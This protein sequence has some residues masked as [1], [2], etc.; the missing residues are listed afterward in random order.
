MTTYLKVNNLEIQYIDNQNR[1]DIFNLK[2]IFNKNNTMVCR[3]YKSNYKNLLNIFNSIISGNKGYLEFGLNDQVNNY[4]ILNFDKDFLNFK[5]KHNEDSLNCS[6][7]EI[8]NIYFE[9]NSITRNT[10][11]KFINEFKIPNSVELDFFKNNIYYNGIYF[12]KDMGVIPSKDEKTFLTNFGSDIEYEQFGDNKYLSVNQ[13]REKFGIKHDIL[14]GVYIYGM[15]IDLQKKYFNAWKK[16]TDSDK[17]RELYLQKKYFNIWKNKTIN[18]DE[19]EKIFDEGY[20]VIMIEYEKNKYLINRIKYILKNIN[21]N[22]FSII[23]VALEINDKIKVDTK[24][25][26]LQYILKD[27]FEILYDIIEN[28][29]QYIYEKLK[30]LKIGNKSVKLLE[31]LIRV[32][33]YMNDKKYF[34]KCAKIC[35]II[36]YIRDNCIKFE[37][38]PEKDIYYTLVDYIIEYNKYKN[39]EDKDA[40][41]I[42]FDLEITKLIN[43][44]DDEYICDSDDSN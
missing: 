7:S 41:D 14:E 43:T 15:N 3:Y 42:L 36:N 9:N 35:E 27:D 20:D 40:L 29:D 5:Y 12:P 10:L 37:N 13:Y 17:Q 34:S 11:R 33:A 1:V 31:V 21:S 30:N 19:D 28:E 18:L 38:I 24:F 25:E 26:D 16:I 6:Y 22:D 2:F 4:L 32:Y 44:T 39:Y 23:A 8:F